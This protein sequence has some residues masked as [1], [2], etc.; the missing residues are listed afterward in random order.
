[1]EIV[2]RKEYKVPQSMT[3]YGQVEAAGDD[4]KILWRLKSVNHR[5][6]DLSL[7]MPEG[8]EMLENAAATVLK[9]FFRRGHIDG[10]LSLGVEAGGSAALELNEPL[11]HHVMA[12]E[13]RVR[14]IGGTISRPVMDLGDIMVWPGMVRER[15]VDW[16]SRCKDGRLGEV[17]LDVL[18]QAAQTLKVAREEEGRQT[19]LLLSQLLAELRGF[20][21]EVV[22]RIPELRATMKDR[23]RSKIDDWLTNQI[24][25]G[26]FMQELAVQYNRMD[27]SEELGRLLMHCREVDKVMEL[28]DPMGRKLDFLCQELGREANT[29]CSKSQDGHLSRL[30]VEMKVVIEK[31][32]EQVQNLE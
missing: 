7:R 28:G 13:Q 30:G 29:L 11:L 14:A 2:S 1:M 18:R 5:Y 19:A 32:R 17:V 4:F 3:G 25:E 16:A 24:D 10:Y 23:L 21:A 8:M 26:R 6:L 27:V 31:M 15:R 22:N 20:H 12:M 9:E